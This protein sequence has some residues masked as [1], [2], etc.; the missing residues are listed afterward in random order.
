MTSQGIGTGMGSLSRPSSIYSLTLNEVQSYLG[1]PLNSMNRDELLRNVSSG[2]GGLSPQL[3]LE[4]GPATINRQGSV[5]MSSCLSKKTVDEI[6]REIQ[7]S[8]HRQSSLGEITLEDFLSKAGVI[9]DYAGS[10][11]Q[12][13]YV[14]G[15]LGRP[16]PRP[17]GAS[18]GPMLDMMYRDGGGSITTVS[19]VIPARKRAVATVEDVAEKTVERR[20]KRMIK[21]RE[22]AARSRA[23]KQVFFFN[24]INFFSAFF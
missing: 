20:Q 22:S 17:M 21:N 7:T 3:R 14:G 6:W 19:P 12:S 10:L 8:A 11:Q 1:E 9:G 2:T 18:T 23:R 16:V 24:L 5:N 15:Y 4:R 13:S